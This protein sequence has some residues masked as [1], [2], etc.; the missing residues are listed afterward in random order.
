MYLAKTL[1]REDK[2]TA[3]VLKFLDAQSKRDLDLMC[4]LVTDD[5]VYINEPHPPCRTIK[6]RDMFRDVFACSPCIW[7]SEANLE[8]LFYS[9]SKDHTVFTERLDQF[10]VNG[11]WL[12]IPICG[13]FKLRNG[14]I[15]LWKDYWDYSK[16]RTFVDKTYG[17][18]FSLFRKNIFEQ[19]NLVSND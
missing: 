5:I 1:K 6:G 9:R 12:S 8:V 4:D 18:G 17:P 3:V 14:K 16:Y 19:E 2:E 15:Y 10:L 13:Y 7:C 11:K